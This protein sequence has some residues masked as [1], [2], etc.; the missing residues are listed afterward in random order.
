LLVNTFDSLLTLNILHSHEFIYQYFILKVNI[1]T[2]EEENFGSAQCDTD[3][4]SSS[5]YTSFVFSGVA[6]RRP[7]IG[8][9]I[10]RLWVQFLLYKAA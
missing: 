7:G 2:S 5:H 9:A 6:V 3:M 4:T 10:N 1:L 8:L